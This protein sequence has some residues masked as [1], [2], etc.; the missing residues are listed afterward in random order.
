MQHDQDFR[1]TIHSS[2]KTCYLFKI[3]QYSN[4]LHQE[5]LSNQNRRIQST[6]S[7]CPHLQ[8]LNNLT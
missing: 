8:K 1:N 3:I 4:T 6:H 7:V 5:T 2:K